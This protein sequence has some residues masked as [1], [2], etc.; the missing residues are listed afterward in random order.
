MLGFIT[1]KEEWTYPDTQLANLPDGVSIHLA[2][3]GRENIQL[4]LEAKNESANIAVCG[5]EAFEI[6]FFQMLDVA[7]N[8]N[9]CENEEQDG[10]FVITQKEY[11]KPYYCSRKA[12]FKVYEALKPIRDYILPAKDDRFALC[13]TIKPTANSTIGKSEITLQVNDVKINVE[14]NVYNIEIPEESLKV[15][16]WFDL[17]NMGLWHNLNMNSPEYIEMVRVYARAM[18]RIRQTH[19][20]ISYDPVKVVIDIE[21]RQFDFSH[22]KPIIEVFFEEGLQVMEFGNFGSKH[23]DLFTEEIKCCFYP[24]YT[25]SSDEGYYASVAFIQELAEFLK[26]NGWE[27]K[28][29]FHVFDEPDVHI[30]GDKSME[31]RKLQYM[32]IVSLLRKYIPESKTIEAVKTAE[33]KGGVDIWVPLT[34]NYEEFKG[35]FDKIIDTGDEVW[36]YV[37]CVPTGQY[38]NRFLDIDLIKSR[39]IFWG[40]SKYRL[41]GYLHWGFNYAPHENFNPYEESNTPNTAFN[42]IYPAGDAYIVFPG[43][44]EPYIGMRFEAQRKGA[45][46]FELLKLIKEKD[47]KVYN[48]IINSIFLTNT[49]YNGDPKFFQNTRIKMLEILS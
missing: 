6:E 47:I 32:R 45:E 35:E 39:L 3:N 2:K 19:F 44:K 37:C 41:S 43:K 36:C 42:G 27:K 49:E 23:D 30:K 9:E 16:N 34:A 26:V 10:M 24:E 17:D 48:E 21:K 12:P 40:C 29:I 8:Y 20:F 11:E 5:G 22:L 4:I 14:I 25:L 18:R 28:T 33:Y 46:D 15:T 38:L 7:V 1:T 31:M 13:F